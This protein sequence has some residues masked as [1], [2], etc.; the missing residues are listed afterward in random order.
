MSNEAGEAPRRSLLGAAA[1]ALEFYTRI[2]RPASIAFHAVDARRAAAF[3]PLAG[4]VV[5]AIAALVYAL[6]ATVLPAAPAVVIALAA[7]VLVTGALHEDGFADTCD[8]F[9]ARVD[10]AGTLEILKDP[11]CGAYAVIALVL[12]T[13][14]KIAALTAVA[15]AL[16]VYA[17]AATLVAAHALSRFAAVSAMHGRTYARSGDTSARAGEF[18]ATPGARDLGVAAL[19]GLAPLLL[20]PLTGLAWAMACVVPAAL[21]RAWLVAL[22]DRRIGGYTGDCLGAVQQSV[23]VIVLLSAC[24][25]A[26]GSH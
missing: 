20:L 3:A 5:G 2:P 17:V 9:G 21:V 6:A 16:G 12:M 23:E 15:A 10:R 18:A 26:V 14:A 25:A 24:A 22:Y 1:A 4:I 13:A 8:A 7:A 11:R 19:L